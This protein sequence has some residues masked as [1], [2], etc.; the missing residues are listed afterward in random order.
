MTTAPVPI[1]TFTPPPTTE[2]T[3]LSLSKKEALRAARE[4]AR[5][6]QPERA[7]QWVAFYWQLDGLVDLEVA[8]G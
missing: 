4:F 3:C 5:G 2:F 1:P 7:A 8:S 6:K